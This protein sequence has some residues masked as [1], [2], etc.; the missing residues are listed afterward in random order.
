MKKSFLVLIIFLLTI[1]LAFAQGEQENIGS[2]KTKMGLL[3]YSEV[4]EATISIRSGVEKTCKENDVELEIYV[5]EQDYSKV[6]GFLQ[7]L[8]DH[9]CEAIIDATWSA[10]VGLATEMTCK[11]S[12]I[13]LVTCDVE[14]GDYTHLVGPN[15]YGSGRING[16]YAADWIAKKWDGEIDHIIGMYPIFTGDAV[17][18]RLTGCFDVFKEKGLIDEAD[19]ANIVW[20]DGGATDLCYGYV[21]NWLQANPK[22]HH[23]FIINNNDSGA[24][25]SYNAVVAMGR[26]KDCMI[27]SFNCDSFALEHFATTDDSPWKASCN[28]NLSGYGALAVP[29]LLDIVKTGKDNYPHVLSTKTFMIDRSNIGGF[30]KK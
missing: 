12:G 26:E 7:M 8:M 29:M 9:G 28:F 27:T 23:V 20:F 18:G 4:D 24:L 22:A 19:E 5:I 13:P 2:E 15:N 11:K 25:G 3:L 14:Y 6:P 21:L 17:K 1:E 16:E 30:Y 10:E